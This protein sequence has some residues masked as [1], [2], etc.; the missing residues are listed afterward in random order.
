ML[1][2][3]PPHVLGIIEHE[4]ARSFALV[5]LLKYTKSVSSQVHKVSLKLFATAA[6]QFQPKLVA[7][8]LATFGM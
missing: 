5:N 7:R 4:A 2:L 1:Y 8:V 3:E 6:V